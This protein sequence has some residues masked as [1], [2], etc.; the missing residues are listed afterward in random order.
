MQDADTLRPPFR[1]G[2]RMYCDSHDIAPRYR[3]ATV[4]TL[5]R[6]GSVGA[7]AMV[8]GITGDFGSQLVDV[9]HVRAFVDVCGEHDLDV[10]ASAFPDVREDHAASL[11]HMSECVELG[12]APELDAEPRDDVHW[13]RTKAGVWIRR[14]PDLAFTTTR[15]EADN[16]GPVGDRLVRGQMEQ[17]TSVDTIED[18]MTKLEVLTDRARIQP[19][20]GTFDQRG[21]IR[22]PKMVRSDLKRCTPQARLSGG[23]AAWVAHTTSHAEADAFL[24]WTLSEKW[25]PPRAA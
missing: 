5:L 17:I 18:A 19:V 23:L 12:C 25:A 13:T 11:D 2:F 15:H 7:I 16:I 1:P 20:I 6:C 21:V 8:Q 24:E 10:T 9:D 22:T 14:F 3:D 4:D